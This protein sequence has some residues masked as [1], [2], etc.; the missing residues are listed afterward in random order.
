MSQPINH[1]LQR[2]N[3]FRRVPDIPRKHLSSGFAYLPESLQVNRLN[4][5]VPQG[6]TT[7]TTPSNISTSSQVKSPGPCA[8][9]D[10]S[11]SSTEVLI[12]SDASGSNDSRHISTT[13][14][15]YSWVT[16]NYVSDLDSDEEDDPIMAPRRSV[17][18]DVSPSVSDIDQNLNVP[19]DCTS[20]H[21]T[22]DMDYYSPCWHC[23]DSHYGKCEAQKAYEE[24]ARRYWQGNDNDEQLRQTDTRD[25]AAEA[26]ANGRAGRDAAALRADV[27]IS[28]FKEGKESVVGPAKPLESWK[29]WR[30]KK[31][32]REW[33]GKEKVEGTGRDFLEGRINMNGELV[34]NA[35]G[36]GVAERK[37]K[38]K[39][40][41]GT[42]RFVERFFG[43][44]V[45]IAASCG[46]CCIG[47]Y[48]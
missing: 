13:P 4:H 32:T 27:R 46:C 38:T 47:R 40:K 33:K 44:L 11:N 22:C 36:S 8:P 43:E 24:L 20:E 30:R 31:K 7:S 1:P 23:S 34:G 5:P 28:R 16:D 41:K 2:R 39:N 12:S 21:T 3:A 48:W 14:R 37:P 42:R 18:P 9:S 29:M 10:P 26:N 19:P 45:I 6:T 17:S 35:R 25:F 15:R